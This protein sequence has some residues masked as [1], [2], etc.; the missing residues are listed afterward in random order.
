MLLVNNLSNEMNTV[1]GIDIQYQQG[2]KVGLPV[3]LIIALIIVLSAAAGW[4]ITTIAMEREKTKR[5]NDSYDANKWVVNKKQ[6]IAGMVT[7][8]QISQEAADSI[9]KTLDGVSAVANKVA[10][11][12]AKSKSGIF[13]DVADLLKWG[14]IGY[15]GFIGYKSFAKK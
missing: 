5:I 3:L 1:R 4:T 8:H 6:E 15:I 14:V 13:S 9:N 2:G 10:D 12:A 11:N 7:A